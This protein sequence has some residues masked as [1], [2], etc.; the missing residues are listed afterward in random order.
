MNR[1]KPCV[2][3]YVCCSLISGTHAT[4]TFVAYFVIS[5]NCHIK[6]L[7][8]IITV[9]IWKKQKLRWKDLIKI[10]IQRSMCIVHMQYTV[11]DIHKSSS[12]YYGSLASDIRF[13]SKQKEKICVHFV[14]FVKYIIIKDYWNSS[15]QWTRMSFPWAFNFKQR[16]DEFA[17]KNMK[18]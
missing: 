8:L 14:L 4:Q 2:L 10:K 7:S 9:T 15:R 1:F 6:R 5:W 16:T 11:R 13:I 18:F 17:K 12:V 3:F